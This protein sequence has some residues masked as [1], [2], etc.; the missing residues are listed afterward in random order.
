MAED[1]VQI[2][3][4]RCLGSRFQMLLAAVFLC[5]CRFAAVESGDTVIVAPAQTIAADL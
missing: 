3:I 5:G 4:S 1:K 2:S